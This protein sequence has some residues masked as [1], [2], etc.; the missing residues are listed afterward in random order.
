M[1]EDLNGQHACPEQ[2]AAARESGLLTDVAA[3]MP[4]SSSSQSSSKSF[5]GVCLRPDYTRV[6][7]SFL[8]DTHSVC[9]NCRDIC[10]P[11]RRFA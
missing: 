6:L 10:N 5:R 9:V 4:G 1:V 3:S 2:P 7:G 8:Q 11:D